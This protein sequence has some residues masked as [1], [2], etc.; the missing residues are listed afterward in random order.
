MCSVGGKTRQL[1]FLVVID[2]RGSDVVCERYLDLKTT[3]IV[4]VSTYPLLDSDMGIR[5]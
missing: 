3:T 4:E 1:I 5:G 2:C